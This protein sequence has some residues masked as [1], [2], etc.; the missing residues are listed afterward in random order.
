MRMMTEK[1]IIEMKR[2][3]N[4]HEIEIETERVMKTKRVMNIRV[5]YRIASII[6]MI[7]KFLKNEVIEMIV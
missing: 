4:I 2:V 3:K 1:Q 7:D 5:V 6:E